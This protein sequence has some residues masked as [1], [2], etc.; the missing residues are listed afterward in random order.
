MHG[1]L[2]FTAFELKTSAVGRVHTLFKRQLLSERSQFK[3]YI[4]SRL[5]SQRAY[6]THLA[7]R[8]LTLMV[9]PEPVRCCYRW[10]G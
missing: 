2:L 4:Q 8:A 1:S 10:F 6:L 7:S 9:R 5:L 3:Y